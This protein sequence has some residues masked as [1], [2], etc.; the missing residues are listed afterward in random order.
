V[1]RG[2]RDETGRLL[3][4]GSLPTTSPFGAIATIA[5]NAGSNSS[6]FPASNSRR[7]RPSVRAAALASRT[8]LGVLG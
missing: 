1:P 5:A 8:I 2:K 3:K 6:S 4:Y 7:S